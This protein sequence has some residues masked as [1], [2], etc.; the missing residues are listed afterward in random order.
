MT[1]WPI[2][3]TNTP[4]T[5]RTRITSRRNDIQNK[6]FIVFKINYVFLNIFFKKFSV[7]AVVLITLTIFKTMVG[8][9]IMCMFVEIRGNEKAGV[10]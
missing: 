1:K 4:S 10:Q 2:Q 6:P 7:T 3:K 9:N 5:V 8:H